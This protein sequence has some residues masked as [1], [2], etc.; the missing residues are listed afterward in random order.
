[1]NPDFQRSIFLFA[2]GLNLLII[3][4][5]R[6]ILRNRLSIFNWYGKP[7]FF[8]INN[9]NDINALNVAI[10]RKR[11]GWRPLAVHILGNESSTKKISEI[12]I[13]SSIEEMINL[14][15]KYQIDSVFFTS[16]P[17]FSPDQI[18]FSVIRKF[19]AHFNSIILMSSTF[20]FGSVMACVFR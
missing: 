3:P 18:K 5:I 7:I 14:G 10:R 8:I 2:W 13:V 19:N 11:V 1:V 20:E 16:D 6:I 15:N 4:L 12:P 9:D 17:F